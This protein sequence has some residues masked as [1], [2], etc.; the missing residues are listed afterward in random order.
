MKKA[1]HYL[2]FSQVARPGKVINIKSSIPTQLVKIF[3]I[4]LGRGGPACI[5]Q[6]NWPCKLQDW[7]VVEQA[8]LIIQVTKD[9]LQLC[10]GRY[11]NQFQLSYG[12]TLYFLAASEWRQAESGHRRGPKTVPAQTTEVMSFS[13]FSL[14]FKPKVLVGM[15]FLW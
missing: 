9:S 5:C 1:E 2:L 8:H 7:G 3:F 6:T 11:I 13:V 15:L 10:F 14:D 12:K 4:L